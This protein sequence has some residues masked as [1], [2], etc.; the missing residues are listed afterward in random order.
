MSFQVF[1]FSSFQVFTLLMTNLNVYAQNYCGTVTPASHQFTA[2]SSSFTPFQ[3]SYTLPIHFYIL[4][5]SGALPGNANPEYNIVQ[6]IRNSL[7]FANVAYAS[8]N[9]SF[10]PSAFTFHESS[11]LFNDGSNVASFYDATHDDDDA[12][13]VYVVN[14]YSENGVVGKTIFPNIINVVNN[15]IT[16]KA[17]SDPSF[18]FV[19]AHELGHYFNVLHTYHG[20]SFI[21]LPETDCN[22]QGDKI[23]DTPQDVTSYEGCPVLYDCTGECNVGCILTPCIIKVKETGEIRNTFQPDKQNIMSD[24]SACGLEYFSQMQLEKIYNELTTNQYRVFLIQGTNPPAVA[25]PVESGYVYRTKD[26]SG[27]IT[28]SQFGDM[29]LQLSKTGVLPITSATPASGGAYNVDKGIFLPQNTSAKIVPKRTGSGNFDVLNGVTTFDRLKIQQHVLG[30]SVLPKPYGWIAADVDNDAEITHDD[31]YE[32]QQL[33]IGNI[34]S[35][36][37]VPSWRMVPTFALQNTVFASEFNNDPFSAIWTLNGEYLGYN[38]VI[39]GGDKT[40]FDDLEIN[41]TNPNLNQSSTFS[42]Q[43]I[44][45]GDVNFSA[46]VNSLNTFRGES[47]ITELRNAEK[48]SLK[49]GDNPCLEAGKTYQ[50]SI[51]AQG[52]SILYGYQ[53]GITFTPSVLNISGV[54]RGDA[55]LFS[56]DNFN[57]NAL[58]EG[59]IKTAWLDTEKENR[60][61]VSEKKDLFKLLTIPKAKVCDLTQVL[62]LNDKALETLFYDENGRLID[63]E[64]LISAQEVKAGDAHNDLLLNMFPNPSSGEVNFEVKLQAK[65][66]L[67]IL[68]RDSFGKTVTLNRTLEAGTNRLTMREEVQTLSSGIIHYTLQ[69]GTKLYTGTFFKL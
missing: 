29:E 34:S 12:I 25:L 24:Y 33:I 35:F 17:V 64:L 36:P 6:H 10:Y 11:V 68:L 13:N 57:L 42:F 4:T 22:L 8:A 47:P 38:E 62:Q 7:N 2:T 63:L 9:I 61:R 23:C 1:K 26:V 18:N 44:K 3:T 5:S 48:Y 45:S 16:I 28:V 15:A 41:L 66:K 46:V 56:L 51:G 52:N 54:D 60:V 40:Y 30:S 27:T 69:I 20:T 55:K 32:V 67:A 19:L 50:I 59:V 65:S 14:G 53:L 49:T 21:T 37:E 43:A 58:K 31:Q 39:T